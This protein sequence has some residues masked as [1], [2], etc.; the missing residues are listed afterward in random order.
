MSTIQLGG[1]CFWGMEELFSSFNGVTDTEVGYAGGKTN[2]PDYKSVSSGN[3]GH[4]ETL[5]IDYDS[6]VVKLEDILHFFFR[7][8]DPT[9]V[10]QQGNDRGSQYRSVIFYANADEKAVAEKVIEEVNQLGRWKKP[11]VTRLEPDNGFHSA[12]AYHQDYLK[13]NPGGYSCHFVRD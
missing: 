4:A 11:I 8:H 13:K 1:G 5:K 7:I 6:K 2:Q 3:S 9:Q 10:N 12:E